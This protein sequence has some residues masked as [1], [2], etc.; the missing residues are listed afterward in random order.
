MQKKPASFV[1]ASLRAQRTE[2]Y[3]S[4]LR[5]LR[6][7]WAAFLSILRETCA[8]SAMHNP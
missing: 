5:S 3:A 8:T 1:L 4:P 2:A 6:P 7:Y